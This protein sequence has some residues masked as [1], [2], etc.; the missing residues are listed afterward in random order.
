MQ[1][2]KIITIIHGIAI[3]NACPFWL[4]YK[5]MLLVIVSMTDWLGFGISGFYAT[6]QILLSFVVQLAAFD[7]ISK[8]LWYFYIFIF[9]IYVNFFVFDMHWPI[10]KEK[11]VQL[12]F[13]S[14]ACTNQLFFRFGT[15]FMLRK[16]SNQH[17]WKHWSCCSFLTWICIS[18]TGLKVTR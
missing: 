10:K 14:V 18:F 16:M 17:W 4:V 1:F 11:L 3:K 7:C 15:P 13:A 12:Q 8:F 9:P 5:K 6:K 2:H